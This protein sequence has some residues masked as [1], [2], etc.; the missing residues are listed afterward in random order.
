LTLPAFLR[1]D[2]DPSCDLHL[3][4]FISALRTYLIITTHH[5]ILMV[6]RS[7]LARANSF[8]SKRA[9]ITTLS[10]RAC[11]DAARVILREI[12]AAPTPPQPLWT[13]PYHVVGAATVVLIDLLQNAGAPQDDQ[14]AEMETNAKRAEVSGA[15]AALRRMEIPSSIAR[16]G[17][18]ILEDLVDEEGRWR[19]SSYRRKRKAEGGVGEVVKRMAV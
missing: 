12:S 19:D 4:A 10:H 3:P 11:I 7:F 8:A 18:K 9:Q 14:D 6:H 1:P 17:V 2:T 5:K 15:L 13:I 16:R